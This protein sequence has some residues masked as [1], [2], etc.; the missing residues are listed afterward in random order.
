MKQTGVYLDDVF[1]DTSFVKGLYSNSYGL[2]WK[3]VQRRENKNLTPAEV[4]LKNNNSSQDLFNSNNN[5][6]NSNSGSNVNSQNSDSTDDEFSIDG[7]SY[8]EYI[9]SI[10][11]AIEGWYH[12]IDQ[13]YMEY[14]VIDHTNNKIISNTSSNLGVFYD[15][16]KDLDTTDNNSS[17]LS[18]NK[19][20]SENY[21]NEDLTSYIKS[22]SYAVVI[23]FDEKGTIKIPYIKGAKE[24]SLNLLNALD[25]NDEIF[26]SNNPTSFA[27]YTRP[28]NITIVF[29]VPS[30]ATYFNNIN[31]FENWIY[32][33][34]FTDLTFMYYSV[35]ISLIILLMA[36]FLPFI[37]TWQLE[38]GVHLKIPF[39]VNVIGIGL[40]LFLYY[41][42]SYITLSLLD[43]WQ[44]TL[45][46]YSI[47]DWSAGLIIDLFSL[48]MWVVIMGL[49]F[50]I[51]LSLRQIFTLGPIR[52]IK[53][54]TITANLYKKVVSLSKRIINSV[55]SIDLTNPTDKA[56]L[57]ILGLNFVIISVVCIF[58]VFGIVALII[59]T[60]ILYFLLRKYFNDLQQKYS[61]LLKATNRIAEGNLDIVIDQNLGVFEPLKTEL[62]KVQ[63]GFKKAVDEEIKS[64]KMRTELITNVSHD[65]KTPLT[66]IITYINLLKEGNITE[67][68]RDSYLNTLDAKAQRLKILIEDLFEMSKVSSKNIT[69]NLVDVDLKSLLKQV[70]LELSDKIEASRIELRYNLPDEKITLTLDSE[71]TYRIFENLFVNITKYA[72][73]NTRAYIDLLETTEGVSITIKN[74]SAYELDLNENELTE[75]FVRGDKSRNTEG[76][77][78]GLAIAK[79]LTEL[80]GGSFKIV[81]DGDLFKVIVTFY[82]TNVI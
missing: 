62:T 25:L 30:N 31:S 44:K 71:K 20:I 53:E 32:L 24:Y 66:A 72:L 48:F 70:Q 3:A 14:L 43:S 56:I 69:L 19:T 6:S 7:Y 17:S 45:E 36:L 38:T 78:L 65:L 28:E 4:Y 10:N 42:A 74:I 77:G 29:G 23:Q 68:E 67:E 76:S 82:K 5:N 21:S 57:K 59:Y 22:Y 80:Q 34:N 8:D 52:Y 1:N 2:Y 49:L 61:V 75:R 63:T 11:N 60:L 79:S 18:N 26:Y 55:L 35:V 50:T 37:K 33:S 41:F 13:R 58:W 9:N 47:P 73:P 54:K 15:I 39:E 46:Q 40:V 27:G 81:T 51:L 64:Q 16:S 12:N